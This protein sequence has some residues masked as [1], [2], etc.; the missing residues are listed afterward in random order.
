MSK[1]FTVTGTPEVPWF[2]THIADI[3]NIGKTLLGEGDGIEMTDHPG[4]ND[5]E[6]KGRRD[7]ISKLAL[8]ADI[9]DK[10]IPIVD[11]TK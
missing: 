3:N 4:F 6:Y 9:F 10:H 5:K 11:Y 8:N 7:Y 2:P 1:H